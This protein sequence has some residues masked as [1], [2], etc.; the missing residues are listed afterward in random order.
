MRKIQRAIF[1]LTPGI[2]MRFLAKKCENI[3]KSRQKM[4]PAF[5]N[6]VELDQ[7]ASSEANWS[8]S[9]LFVIKYVNLYQQPR[10]SHLIGSALLVWN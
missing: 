5:A 3:A 9:A 7:L 2:L 6:S 10:S 4:I 1:F 8:E